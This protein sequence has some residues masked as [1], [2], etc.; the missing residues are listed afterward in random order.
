MGQTRKRLRRKTAVSPL[1]YADGLV[2]HMPTW[3]PYL[4]LQ[5]MSYIHRS[6]PSE[7]T[8]DSVKCLRFLCKSMQDAWENYFYVNLHIDVEWI[9]GFQIIV[10]AESVTFLRSDDASHRILAYPF[11]SGYRSVCYY[12]VVTL[13]WKSLLILQRNNHFRSRSRHKRYDWR[14]YAACW[15]MGFRMPPLVF[16]DVFHPTGSLLWYKKPGERFNQ[17][18]EVTEAVLGT[19]I[20]G[21]SSDEVARV[22]AAVSKGAS[23]AARV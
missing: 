14:D 11:L 22:L 13:P 2:L 15:G 21:L 6:S 5:D 20:N 1:N 17:F 10:P 7:F 9:R 3:M 4:C 23:E 16:Q 18:D 8:W 19:Y 12:A